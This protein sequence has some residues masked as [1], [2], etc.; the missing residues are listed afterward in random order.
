MRA[1]KPCSV[2]L[3]RFK[4]K[5]RPTRLFYALGTGC[6]LSLRILITAIVIS[7]IAVKVLPG[8]LQKISVV[9]RRIVN[10]INLLI[11]VE[12]DEM[13]IYQLSLTRRDYGISYGLKKK[14]NGLLSGEKSLIYVLF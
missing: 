6:K 13:E 10:P 2:E 1:K 7:L 8:S 4:S 5:A 11:W 14:N 9:L 3:I 12:L